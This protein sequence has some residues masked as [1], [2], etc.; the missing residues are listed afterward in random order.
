M[1][2]H[3]DGFALLWS[4]ALA[5]ALVIIGMAGLSLCVLTLSHARAGNAADLA[6][7][8]AASNVLDPCGS[9][10]RVAAANSAKLIDCTLVEGDVIVRVQVRAPAI[11]QWLGR[12]RLEVASRAGPSTE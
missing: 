10:N 2:N 3:D 12:D 1:R 7:I 8:A 11:A 9:A 4:L 5:G 6:A